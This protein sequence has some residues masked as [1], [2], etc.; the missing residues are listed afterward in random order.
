MNIKTLFE[1]SHR[2]IIC[3]VNKYFLGGV[4]LLRLCY[5]KKSHEIILVLSNPLGDCVYG[6]AYADSLR[7]ERNKEL[8]IYSD[9]RRKSLVESY[10]INANVIYL[11]CDSKDWLRMQYMNGCKW[12]VLLGK[13]YGVY[14]IVPWVVY[15]FDRYEKLSALDLIRDRMFEIST[16]S[17]IHYPNFSDYRIQAI[18]GFDQIKDRV[19]VINPY[20]GSMNKFD[21]SFFVEVSNKLKENDF[22]VY[23]NV[24]GDQKVVE[25]THRLECT[26]EELYAICDNIPLVVSVRSGIIDLCISAKTN[27]FVIYFLKKYRNKAK[28]FWGQYNLSAWKTNNV[29][30]VIF[31]D[32]QQAMKSF[33]NFLSKIV[34]MHN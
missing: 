27:F 16:N 32:R 5:K 9:I 23:T 4:E 2:R 15:P 7:L 12:Y 20:S 33:N 24:V 30:E 18:D 31:E 14:N 34:K 1:K 17:P 25:G 29:E 3:L 6:L 19:V 26:V 22:I 28:G 13:R 10:H 11:S 8:S 21:S